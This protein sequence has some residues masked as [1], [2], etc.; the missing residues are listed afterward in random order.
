MGMP[1]LYHG[2][3]ALVPTVT[4]T[5]RSPILKREPAMDQERDQNDPSDVDDGG[6]GPIRRHR[7]RKRALGAI[8]L[9]AL[10]AGAVW[11][12]LEAFDSARNPCQRVRDYTCRRE[13]GSARC[14]SFQELLRDSVEDPSPQV[15]GEIR[16]QCLTR[17]VRL[18]KDE[19]VEVP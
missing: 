4:A 8:A 14:Q 16:N 13:P 2:S 11:V 7:T 3:G 17:I 1:R 15:R 9:G 5:G 6:P 12:V 18:K 19:G 10:G